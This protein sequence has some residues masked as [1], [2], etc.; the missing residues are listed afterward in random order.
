MKTVQK[1]IKIKLICNNSIDFVNIYRIIRNSKIIL[2]FIL[3]V[4]FF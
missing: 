4:S 1:K 2:E 3:F